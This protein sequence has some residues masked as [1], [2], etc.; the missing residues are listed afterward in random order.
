M[1]VPP[2][3][4]RILRFVCAVTGPSVGAAAAA[5]GLRAHSEREQRA[6]AGARSLLQQPLEQQHCLCDLHPIGQSQ[7]YHVH[8][9]GEPFCLALVVPARTVPLICLCLRLVQVC[10]ASSFCVICIEVH[11]SVSSM[12]ETAVC[13][14][15]RT[16]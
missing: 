10:R 9:P 8:V 11:Y 1:L 2:I 15:M 5:G 6:R 13:L 7:R 14:E 4:M 16:I 3:R 12:S